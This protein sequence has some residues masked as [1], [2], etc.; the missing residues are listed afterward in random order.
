MFNRS[1]NKQTNR[2]KDEADHSIE[3]LWKAVKQV[4]EE[5]PKET[6][7]IEYGHLYANYNEC[8]KHNG[9]THMM[10]WER[11]SVMVSD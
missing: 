8:L 7:S 4:F 1:K 5:Y 2:L 3:G 11:N 9:N 10:E 6:I